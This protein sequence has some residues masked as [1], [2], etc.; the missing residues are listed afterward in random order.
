MKFPC[1]SLDFSW[2]RWNS[3]KCG[4]LSSRVLD[5]DCFFRPNWILTLFFICS[6]LVARS[7][8]PPRAINRP[9]PATKP[10]YVATVVF[11]PPSL[12]LEIFLRYLTLWSPES[13]WLNAAKSPPSWNGNFSRDP[14][15]KERKG[16]VPGDCEKGVQVF[17][18]VASMRD[19][20]GAPK[21]S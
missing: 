13:R 12:A 19:R 4:F 21:T 6:R 11:L 1:V 2:L 8:R 20:R 15:G 10:I 18:Y 7:P 17:R 16:C 9:P 5:F 3:R 14:C